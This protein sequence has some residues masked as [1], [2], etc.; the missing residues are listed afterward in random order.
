MFGQFEKPNASGNIDGGKRESRPETTVEDM[1]VG[2]P[3]GAEGRFVER[4]GISRIETGKETILS[5]SVTDNLTRQG[6]DPKMVRS[7][8]TGDYLYNVVGEGFLVTDRS[9][10]AVDI[11]E[12]KDGKPGEIS[13]CIELRGRTVK[14]QEYRYLTQSRDG[15]KRK[16][17]IYDLVFKD[18]SLDASDLLD[19]VA[20][21]LPAQYLD[22][23]DE[24]WIERKSQDAGKTRQEISPFS[25]KNVIVLCIDP[26]DVSD[27]NKAELKKT[28]YHEL[29]HSIIKM[30]NK[31][32]VHPGAT[33]KKAMEK[34]GTTMSTYAAKQRYPGMYEGMPDNGEIEDVAEAFCAYFASDGAHDDKYRG[35]RAATEAR[36]EI[37]EKIGQFME[38]R[39]SLIDSVKNLLRKENPLS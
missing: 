34:D 14:A 32:N 5:L 29:G 3:V 31:G 2:P 25:K 36:F 38:R 23:V 20:A 21:S 26:D 16:I 9:A 35:V 15:Q 10:D 19:D 37:I 28:L 18:R 12:L 33:W 6:W 24:I 7:A 27:A 30:L 1:L 39:R 13:G 22:C 11:V 17:R 4:V 8:E